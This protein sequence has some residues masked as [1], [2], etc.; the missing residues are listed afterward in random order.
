M[1]LGTCNISFKSRDE[2]I[3]EYVINYTQI[4]RKDTNYTFLG[5]LIMF[6]FGDDSNKYIELLVYQLT[7]TFPN[8]SRNCTIIGKKNSIKVFLNASEEIYYCKP[9]EETG[10]E[11]DEGVDEDD[12]GGS[13]VS[14][15][16]IRMH[17]SEHFMVSLIVC[18]I[19]DLFL[20]IIILTYRKAHKKSKPV[21]KET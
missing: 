10:V 7:I 13:R 18:F 16:G 4:F 14:T 12:D 15:A 5:P 11:D 8:A 1:K 6:K 2:S 20:M 21:L 3:I 19:I 9:P 17:Y